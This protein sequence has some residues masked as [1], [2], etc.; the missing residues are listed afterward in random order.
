MS[1]IVWLGP[2]AKSQVGVTSRDGDR[3]GFIQCKG[4]GSPSCGQIADS[5]PQATKIASLLAAAKLDPAD[6]DDVILRAFSAGGS[7]IKRALLGEDAQRV[8]AVILSDA[9]YS[10]W[11]SPGQPTPPEGFVRFGL[12]ALKGDRMLVATASSA[13]NGKMP[14]GSQTLEALKNELER[15]SGVVLVEGGSIPGVSTQPVRMWSSGSVLLADYGNLTTHTQHATVLAPLIWSNVVVPWLDSGSPAQPGPPVP[16][17]PSL[18]SQLGECMP[19]WAIALIALS[20][21]G[22]GFAATRRMLKNA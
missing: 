16:P 18:P 4:D 19:A 2:V 17:G 9:T 8:R 15:R 5:W 13:P 21:I 7:A 3:V 11:G 6:P 20:A 1:Q 14:N 22:A 10:D 12:E